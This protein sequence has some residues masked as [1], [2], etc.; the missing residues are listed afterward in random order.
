MSVLQKPIV[1]EK[2]T[3]QSEDLNRY[4]FKVDREANKIQIKRAVEDMYG[5]S[6]VSVNTLRYG[7]KKKSRFTKAGTVLGKTAGYKKAIVTLA[8][9]DT[10]DFYSNI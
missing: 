6:V 4:G 1:T 10:I 5:V 2:M 8:E 3:A 7:G 9:G